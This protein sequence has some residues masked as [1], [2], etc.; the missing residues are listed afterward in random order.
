MADLEIIA[1]ETFNA[2]EATIL[3]R[4]M[5]RTVLKYFAY[6]VAKA[7]AEAKAEEVE[8]K[9][10]QR[11]KEK[12]NLTDAEKNKL[13]EAENTARIASLVA[14]LVGDVVNVVNMTTESA[15]TRCWRALPNRIFLIRT[16]LPVGTHNLTLSFLGPDGKNKT[17]QTLRN[18]EILPN[19]ITFLNYRTYE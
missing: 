7:I 1:I 17:S 19:R 10:K 4:T 6:R 15:D 2:Q 13:I 18:V 8:E 12:E 5:T 14:N 9:R 3:A 11:E 16:H